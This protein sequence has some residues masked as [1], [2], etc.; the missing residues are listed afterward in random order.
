MWFTYL[1]QEI[2]LWIYT[3]YWQTRLAA[4]HVV[5]R[6]YGG[7]NSNLLM[8][9]RERHMKPNDLVSCQRGGL[10]DGPFSPTAASQTPAAKAK[11][12]LSWMGTRHVRACLIIAEG[13]L[14][15]RGQPTSCQCWTSQQ[16]YHRKPFALWQTKDKSQLLHQPEVSSSW[17]YLL[18]WGQGVSYV[19][20][21]PYIISSV[22]IFSPFS[23]EQT[24]WS[25]FLFLFKDCK[26]R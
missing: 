23:S 12:W 6:V 19:T 16:S 1:N 18:V 5:F 7:M 4:S 26:F 15:M 14:R 24:N 9:G 21:Q 17:S 8:Q 13:V 2:N 22:L 10:I 11:E 25:P 3:F 20:T